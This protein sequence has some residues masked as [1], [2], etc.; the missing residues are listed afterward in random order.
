MKPRVVILGGG[1][2]GGGG[3]LKLFK[4][5]AQ[6]VVVDKNEKHTKQPQI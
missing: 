3:A 4:A 6:V 5:E 1:F 2:G